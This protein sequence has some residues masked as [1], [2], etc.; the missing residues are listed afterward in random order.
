MSGFRAN[1]LAVVVNNGK[2]RPIL[3][4][5]GPM[6]MWIRGKWRSCTVHMGTAKQ[7]GEALREAGQEAEFSKFDLQDAYKLVPAKV[8]DYRLQGFAV[9]NQSIT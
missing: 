6:I 3:N 1:P 9:S 7:F 8:S 5:S 4:L 2:V